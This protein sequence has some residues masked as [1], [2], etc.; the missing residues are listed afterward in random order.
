MTSRGSPINCIHNARP[1][2]M[3]KLLFKSD[4]LLNNTEAVDKSYLI[5]RQLTVNYH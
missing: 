5:Y 4:A 1:V 2:R 3:G